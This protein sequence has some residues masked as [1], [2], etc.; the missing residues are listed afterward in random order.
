MAGKFSLTSEIEWLE[1]QVRYKGPVLFPPMEPY[2][3][4]MLYFQATNLNGHWYHNG[5]IITFKRDNDAVDS[6]GNDIFDLISDHFQSANEG[7]W[8][9]H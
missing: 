1:E 4:P 2:F 7:E 5:I 6:E 8:D 9:W 3:V